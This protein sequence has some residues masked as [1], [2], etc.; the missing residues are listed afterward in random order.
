MKEMWEWYFSRK[1]SLLRCLSKQQAKKGQW[2]KEVWLCWFLTS[3]VKAL[4]SRYCSMF[5]RLVGECVGNRVGVNAWENRL[6]TVWVIRH[7]FPIRK[8]RNLIIIPTE[9][10]Q[11]LVFFSYRIRQHVFFISVALRPWAGQGLLL[12]K[13]PRSHTTTHHS[14]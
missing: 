14:Q 9:M 2:G 5:V 6:L 11:L 3:E 10:L 4:W 8:S 1:L 7:G 12:F 13:A